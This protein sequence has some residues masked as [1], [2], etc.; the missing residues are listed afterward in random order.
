MWN[1]LLAS[2]LALS[3][4]NVKVAP[5]AGEPVSGAL[6]RVSAE[7]IVLTTTA[8]ERKFDLKSI[9]AMTRSDDLPPTDVP[10]EIRVTLQDGSV[11][12]AETFVVKQGKAAIR[13]IGGLQVET[14]TR[15]IRSVRLKAPLDLVETAWQEYVD[16]PAT[17]DV[18]VVRKTSR[19]TEGEEKPSIVLDR[20][21]GVVQEVTPEIVKFEFD[22]DTIDVRREKLE[23]IIYFSPVSRD[24][25]LPACRLTDTA[26]SFWNV[27]SI[28]SEGDQLLVET[29]AGLTASLP[30][31][32][33][34]KL[35]FSVGNTLYLSDMEPD[36]VEWTPFFESPATQARL[37]KLYLPRR[38][39]AFEGGRLMLR[40]RSYDKGLAVHSRTKIVYRI[41]K[42]SKK[43]VATVGIDDRVGADGKVQLVISDDNK[44]LLDK[45]IAGKDDPLDVIIDLTGVRRLTILVDFG[46]EI[47]IGDH[48]DFCNARITK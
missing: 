5:L 4:V 34:R 9:V 3:V 14:R 30:F 16:G 17:G 41:P 40:S 46:D 36:S 7:E 18:I 45:S 23:G 19:P 26:G 13:L 48:L 15:S 1:L 38:D 2:T 35:D 37:A 28:R 20:L 22:G 47:D 12:L 29:T 33:L 25:P 44:I 8:G 42:D 32:S 10:T 31:A 39:M 27:K 43:F 21:E 11:L 6:A 24:L